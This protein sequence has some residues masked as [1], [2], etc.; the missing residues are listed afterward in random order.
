MIQ[1]LELPTKKN[2]QCPYCKNTNTEL[3]DVEKVYIDEENLKYA[4]DNGIKR[5]RYCFCCTAS[6]YHPDAV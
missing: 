1:P 3:V 2:T 6:W 5:L 4:K